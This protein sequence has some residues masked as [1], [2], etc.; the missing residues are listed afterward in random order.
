MAVFGQNQLSVAEVLQNTLQNN[1]QISIQRL[2]KKEA[3]L[4]NS[5][6]MAGRYPTLGINGE[7]SYTLSDADTLD[8]KNGRYAASLSAGWV[9]FNGFKVNYT[10]HNLRLN[11]DLAGGVLAVLLETSVQSA[12]LAYY[13]IV[14]HQKTLSALFG[15]YGALKNQIRSRTYSQ[16]NWLG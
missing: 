6:G 10:K 2:N 9:L 4:S 12:V 1:Y 13:S 8:A 14:Y 3:K 7:A 15:C 11:S 16:R 5:W